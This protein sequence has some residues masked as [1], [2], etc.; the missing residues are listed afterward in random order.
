MRGGLLAPSWPG[1]PYIQNYFDIAFPTNV[2]QAVDNAVADFFAG[3]GTPATIVQT[4]NQAA[5]TS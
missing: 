2:G 3:Q 1:R 5:S 4:V